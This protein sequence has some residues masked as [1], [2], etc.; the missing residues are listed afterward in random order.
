MNIQVPVAFQLRIELQALSNALLRAT[1]DRLKLLRLAESALTTAESSGLGDAT[2][3]GRLRVLRDTLLRD[4]PVD[5][6]DASAV[7]RRLAGTVDVAARESVR[8]GAALAR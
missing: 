6:A 4:L 5:R 3:R 7:F 8:Q 2:L 1:S